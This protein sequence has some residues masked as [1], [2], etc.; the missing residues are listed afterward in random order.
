M[1][2]L[3]SLEFVIDPDSFPCIVEMSFQIASLK[4]RKTAKRAHG[5][6][7]NHQIAV[8]G[9]GIP[10][11]LEGHGENWKLSVLIIPLEFSSCQFQQKFLV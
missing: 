11:G 2:L 1:T 6:E 5:D 7:R 3:T 8:I 4:R 9:I 10:T